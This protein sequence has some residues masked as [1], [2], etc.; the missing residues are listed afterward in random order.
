M[1]C[2]PWIAQNSPLRFEQKLPNMQHQ[3]KP[4]DFKSMER[5]FVV[6]AVETAVTAKLPR[7]SV[8]PEYNAVKDKYAMAYFQSPAVRAVMERNMLL[9]ELKDERNKLST[10]R[11]C[12]PTPT[13]DELR[14]R[15]QKFVVDSI[16]MDSTRFKGSLD[17][18]VIPHYQ[19]DHDPNCKKYFERN[20]VKKLMKVTVSPRP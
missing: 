9:R 20:D 4:R 15:Q 10:R 3:Q 7:H 17:H 13:V 2:M 8:I 19:A 11:R 16:K 6:D 1:A 12:K 18:D 5:G 14:Q